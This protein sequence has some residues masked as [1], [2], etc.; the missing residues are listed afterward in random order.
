MNLKSAFLFMIETERIPMK[1]LTFSVDFSFN[2]LLHLNSLDHNLIFFF[3]LT[4]YFELYP[5]FKFEANQV[6]PN[7]N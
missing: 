2:F 4:K 7:H 6:W 3:Y 1:M 5:K